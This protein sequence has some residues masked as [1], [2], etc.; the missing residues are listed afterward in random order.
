[1][2]ACT[3]WNVSFSSEGRKQKVNTSHFIT[4]N[5]ILGIFT[6]TVRIFIFILKGPKNKA[7]PLRSIIWKNTWLYVWP[8]MVFVNTWAVV[9]CIK[10]VQWTIWCSRLSRWK[11]R[12]A[13]SEIEI[14]S[15]ENSST[16]R[17]IFI[18]WRKRLQLYMNPASLV[19][20]IHHRKCGL[21][22]HFYRSHRLNAAL[23]D[24]LQALRLRSCW[25]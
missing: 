18:C 19:N 15:L 12:F 14:K 9:N 5:M 10:E 20:R 23:Q 16:R 25:R 13:L 21:V 17:H 22:A 2:R 6:N 3:K 1:M 4:L 7:T 8:D 11:E 24:N